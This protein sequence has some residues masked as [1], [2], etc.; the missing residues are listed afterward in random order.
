MINTQNGC[1]NEPTIK[2]I[3]E[4]RNMLN[5]HKSIEFD[6]LTMVDQMLY[7]FESKWPIQ[8]NPNGSHNLF[9]VYFLCGLQ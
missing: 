8:T 6:V 7:K 3:L 4:V 5:T 1:G 9:S 2:M